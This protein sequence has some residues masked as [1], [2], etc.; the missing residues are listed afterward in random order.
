MK[1]INKSNDYLVKGSDCMK[2][3]FKQVG[4]AALLLILIIILIAV[5]C[6]LVGLCILI[7]SHNVVVGVICLFI[8]LSLIIGTISYIHDYI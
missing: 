2:E 4:I 1:K 5:I 8:L 7:I 6:G 3:Y